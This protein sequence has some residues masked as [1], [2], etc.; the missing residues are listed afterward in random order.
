MAAL[1]LED[2][3]E[4]TEELGNMEIQAYTDCLEH[5]YWSQRETLVNTILKW[6]EIILSGTTTVAIFAVVFE[7]SEET[8]KIVG[9]ICSLIL[10]VATALMANFKYAESATSH[11]KTANSLEKI[12]REYKTLVSDL[13]DYTSKEIK[14]K[15]DELN[16]RYFDEKDACPLMKK[17]NARAALSVANDVENHFRLQQQI[18]KAR[19]TKY[20]KSMKANITANPGE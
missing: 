17:L 1:S 15:R 11:A 6:I 16:D 4:Y 12:S 3:K 8:M 5:K 9:A 19:D 20:V 7:R 2:R 14:G 13:D 10:F 18:I